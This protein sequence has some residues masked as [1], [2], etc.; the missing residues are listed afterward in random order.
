MEK[1]QNNI[2]QKLLAYREKIDEVDNKIIDLLNFRMKIVKA[3]GEHK[4]DIKD[5]FFIKS[6]READMIKDLVVKA[7]G[8]IPKSIIVE[9]WRKIIT[10]AN[11]LEQDIKIALYNPNKSLEYHHRI[12]EYYSN[13]V[14]IADHSS[15]TNVI[16]EIEKNNAQIGVVS[17]NSKDNL[18]HWWINIANNQ[19]GLKVFAKIPFVI[20]SQDSVQ[21]VDDL[22]IMAIKDAEKSQQD[23]TLLVLEVPGDSSIYALQK[24]FDQNQF[25]ANIIKNVKIKEIYNFTFYLVEVAGFYDQNDAEIESLKNSKL[26]PHIKVIGHYPVPID[27][28]CDDYK[29]IK[30]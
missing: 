23:K 29:N 13:L 19:K 8:A 16:L 15:S 11:M 17:L 21:E 4:S 9:I 27:L 24:L 18:D 14:P 22:F 30:E 12:K 26:K 1:Q 20:D 7:D 28:S 3:V 10:S 2:S 5:K 6:A 25:A